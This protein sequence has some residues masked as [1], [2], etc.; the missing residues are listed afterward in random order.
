MGT[1]APT[2]KGGKGVAEFIPRAILVFLWNPLSDATP[3]RKKKNK[4]R[5][6][7]W[8]LWGCGSKSRAEGSGLG[9]VGSQ[10]MFACLLRGRWVGPKD[11]L[12]WAGE[13]RGWGWRV[14][15]DVG[16]GV[17]VVGFEVQLQGR[18]FRVER[19]E[20]VTT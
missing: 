14:G 1:C 11:W 10:S 20:S 5:G 16:F 9:L 2:R 8:E 17:R 3:F 4:K 6:R 15:C 13:P 7:I 18:W 19:E 12:E